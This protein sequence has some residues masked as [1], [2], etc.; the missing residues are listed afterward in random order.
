GWPNAITNV[1]GTLFFSA[2]DGVSGRE[3]WK[4]DGTS[5]GTALVADILPGVEGRYGPKYLTNI[6]GSLFFTADDGIHG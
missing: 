1:S 4:S 6:E 3:L 5:E 2:N